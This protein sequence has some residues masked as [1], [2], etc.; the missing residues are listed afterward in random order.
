MR[1][2]V[3][4]GA[5]FI[6]QRTVQALV[7]KGHQVCVLDALTL[8]VHP[9]RSWP[10]PLT[11]IA[12]CVEG[13]VRV[14][15]DLLPALRDVDAVV[16]LAAYQDYLPD[17]SNFINT[18]AGSTALLYELIVAHRLPVERIVIASSQSVYGEGAYDC[19][20]H[21]LRYPDA[22]NLK[23]LRAAEW[24]LACETCGRPVSW[25]PTDESHVNPQNPYGISKL[26]QELLGISLG[27]RFGIPT[28]GL[29]YSITQGAGQSFHNAYSG[30]CRTFSICALQRKPLPVY[31]DGQQQRDYVYV[32]DVVSANLLA[33]EDERTDYQAFN[34]GG[35]DGITVL[36]YARLICAVARVDVPINVS[37]NF[38]VGDTRHIVSD[39]SKLMALGW[40]PTLDVA[41]IADEYLQWA[42]TQ[43]LPANVAEA[44]QER[45]RRL[46]AV[47]VAVGPPS[48]LT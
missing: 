26:G 9:D 48:E 41:D 33:L 37:G 44:A 27:R 4:G 24:D 7:R 39:S 47:Q 1:V 23:Q 36:E 13:D 18:N 5:G 35:R 14:A 22:R 21:G 10:R 40:Q 34:V 20:E 17:F 6:G 31:E 15:A 29:R 2:L 19:V 3:T 16:H 11:E 25:R 43:P 30:I 42:A 8:P 32:D 46:A 28:V 12:D 38:R 45:M